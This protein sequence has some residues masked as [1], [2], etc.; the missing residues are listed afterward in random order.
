MR[1][2]EP[3]NRDWDRLD[4]RVIEL[5]RAAGWLVTG[6]LSFT[7]VLGVLVIWLIPDAPR[8]LKYLAGP[9]WLAATLGLAALSHRWPLLDYRHASYRLDPDGIEIRR[10]VL[11]RTSIAVPRSRVQH[12]DVAQGPLERRYGLGTLSIYTAGT[13]HSR[14]DLRGLDHSTALGLRD[15]LLPGGSADAV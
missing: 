5:D 2:V 11:W 6:G 9:A 12:I 14:V 4:P 10:G 7:M 8:W 3:A 1:S 13:E 15:R